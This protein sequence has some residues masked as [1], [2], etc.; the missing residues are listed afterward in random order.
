LRRLSIASRP[1]ATSAT[2]LP[3]A[4]QDLGD[5]FAHRAVVVDDQDA[6]ALERARARRASRGEIDHART[7][8]ILRASSNPAPAM[9]CSLL[10]V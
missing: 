9:S 5:R 7:A 8:E 2:A 3:S 1:F 6:P 10:Q 4:P